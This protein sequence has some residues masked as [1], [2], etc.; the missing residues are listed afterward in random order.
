MNPF[1][2]GCLEMLPTVPLEPEQRETVWPL[3]YSYT[4]YFGASDH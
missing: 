1:L 2:L 4:N 3:I